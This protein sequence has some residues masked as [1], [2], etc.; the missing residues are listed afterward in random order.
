MKEVVNFDP[1]RFPLQMALKE[2][3][4][5][6]GKPREREAPNIYRPGI[7]SCEQ[8]NEDQTTGTGV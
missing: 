3:E 2:T 8:V 5:L 1:L 6:W 7:L 4:I